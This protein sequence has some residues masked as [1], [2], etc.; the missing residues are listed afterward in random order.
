M[1]YNLGIFFLKYFNVPTDSDDPDSFQ[2]KHLSDEQKA[3]IKKDKEDKIELDKLDFLKTTPE[4]KTL[5]AAKTIDDLGKVFKAL[6]KE[7]QTKFSKLVTEFKLE[8]SK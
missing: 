4:G 5:K 1:D 7:N 6:S 2:E 3:K 8:L